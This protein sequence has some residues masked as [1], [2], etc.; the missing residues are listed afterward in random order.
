MISRPQVIAAAA[1]AVGCL[2][3]LAVCAYVVIVTG[4]IKPGA[5][6]PIPG[7][8]SWAGKTSLKAY[9]HG[10]APKDKNPLPTD[11]KQLMSGAK[12]Y[13]A[14]C[15]FCHGY[16]DAQ[17]SPSGQGMYQKPPLIPRR[18]WSDK[19]DGRLFWYIDHGIRMTAMPSYHQT[20]SKDE[21]WQIVLFLKNMR[22][23]PSSVDAYWRAAQA[24]GAG[25]EQP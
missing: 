15:A 24:P 12:L 22:H 18:D 16:A 7:I 20:L 1:G 9:V 2:V 17:L 13:L 6:E 14:N 3:V 8:E 25:Q 19:N 4:T 10:N 5:D 23:L 11:E 21:I